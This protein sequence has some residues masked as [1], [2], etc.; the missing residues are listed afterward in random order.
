MNRFRQS[1]CRKGTLLHRLPRFSGQV[2]FRSYR[3]NIEDSFLKHLTTQPNTEKGEQVSQPRPPLGWTDS[4][5]PTIVVTLATAA[6]LVVAAPLVAAMLLWFFVNDPQNTKTV[7]FL[8]IGF[9][10]GFLLLVTLSGR[11]SGHEVRNS[12]IVPPMI[13]LIG[14][15]VLFVWANRPEPQYAMNE[16]DFKM[17]LSDPLFVHSLVMPLAPSQERAVRSAIAEGTVTPDGIDRFLNCC[18]GKFELNVAQSSH[19]TGEKFLWITQHGGLDARRA[20][21]KNLTVPGYV[22]RVLIQDPNPGVAAVA[23]QAAAERLCDPEAMRSITKYQGGDP[24]LPN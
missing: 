15:F 9:I 18:S 16:Q 7:F 13:P 14:V 11:A 2:N 20:V 24:S 5:A 21:A 8:V 4:I 19:T 22:L 6:L 1:K 12:Y 10:L 17:R 3:S 23:R